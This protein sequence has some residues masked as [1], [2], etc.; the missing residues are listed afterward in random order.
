MTPDNKA[1]V[2]YLGI[3]LLFIGSSFLYTRR[4]K[5]SQT[6]QQAMIWG[7]IFVGAIIAYGFK[8]VLKS[9]IYPSQAVQTATGSI[10]LTRARDGHF[11]AALSV[12]GRSVDFI[13]DTGASGVVLSKQDAQRIGIDVKNLNYLGT[14]NTANGAVRIAFIKLGVVKLGNFV[15]YDVTASVNDG[16]LF[17]SL[18]G[19]DYLN[20]FSEFKIN[21][22]TLTLTR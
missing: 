13:I 6:L 7:L 1:Y 15:D 3:L 4:E 12:N 20:R 19:M 2:F 11:H 21:G 16:E 18:L 9:Q 5:L 8:D 10:T 14:A 17:G 22:D